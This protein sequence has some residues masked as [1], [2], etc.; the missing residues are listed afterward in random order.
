MPVTAQRNY[1]PFY[2]G[3]YDE[4]MH[5][6]VISTEPQKDSSFDSPQAM[7]TKTLFDFVSSM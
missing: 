4:K 6:V 7:K 1:T 5:Y 3:K 2:P